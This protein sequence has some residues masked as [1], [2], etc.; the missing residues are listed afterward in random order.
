MAYHAIAVLQIVPPTPSIGRVLQEEVAHGVQRFCIYQGCTWLPSHH[1]LCFLLLTR[2]CIASRTVN[3]SIYNTQT[4]ADR[5]TSNKPGTG[6]QLWY[7]Q[8][9]VSAISMMVECTYS[10]QANRHAH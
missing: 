10:Y 7:Q 6:V 8:I 4:V 3:T 5:K 2:P 1:A 9:R